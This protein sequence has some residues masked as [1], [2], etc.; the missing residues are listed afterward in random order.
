M[1]KKKR[2]IAV[3][4]IT[5]G[6]RLRAEL[7]VPAGAGDEAECVRGEAGALVKLENL[8]HV[9]ARADELGDVVV[10]DGH[11]TQVDGLE[12]LKRRGELREPRRGVG[13]PIVGYEAV[14]GGAGPPL[15]RERLEPREASAEAGRL[16]GV[17]EADGDVLARERVGAVPAA[18]HERGGLPVARVVDVSE[19]EVQR[20]LGDG[21]AA[22]R[23]LAAH[24]AGRGSATTRD[25][26]A[27]DLG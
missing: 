20:L 21:A 17:A 18:A 3:L 23:H 27:G 19:H 13:A 26:V 22:L 2:K 5:R 16:G 9:S 1:K 6:R 8:Q 12:A 14:H 15:D 10:G 25:R 11:A 4:Q 24:R 7:L